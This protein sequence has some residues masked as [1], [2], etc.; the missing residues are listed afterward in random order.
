MK[1]IQIKIDD[2]KK[3]IE[4]AE[5]EITHD[6]SLSSTLKIDLI[7][8]CDTHTGSDELLVTVKSSYQECIGY[9]LHN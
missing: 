7:N 6:S 2:L 5:E 3:I 9:E 4:R 1:T 8:E